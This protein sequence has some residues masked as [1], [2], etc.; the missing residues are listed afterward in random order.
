[1]AEQT[2]FKALSDSVSGCLT[3]EHPQ[4]RKSRQMF[5]LC[6]DGREFTG[7]QGVFGVM[8]LGVPLAGSKFWLSILTELHNRGLEDIFIV[9]TD[10]LK[11]FSEAIE[12]VYPKAITQT[13]HRASDQKFDGVRFVQASE[14]SGGGFEADLQSG[15]PR[16]SVGEA[17]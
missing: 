16:R 14:G 15:E 17:G 4:G 5:G 6:G 12:A 1:M 7:S 9:C 8:D 11:G 13:W 3:G 2:A 10:G